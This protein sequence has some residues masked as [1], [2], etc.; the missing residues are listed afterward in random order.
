MV[1]PPIRS[2]TVL[3]PRLL[4][5]L[6]AGV[7]GRVILLSAPAGFGKTT[8]MAHWLLGDSGRPAA[9][10]ELDEGDNDPVRFWSYFT[11][12]LQKLW[13]TAGRDIVPMLT[14]SRPIPPQAILTILIN[15]LS[16]APSDSPCL[17]ALDDLHLVTAAPI[18]EGL[19]FFIEHMPEELKIVIG[20]RTDPEDLPLA[21]LRARRQLAE[22]RLSD[23]RF[24][25]EEAAEFLTRSMKLPLSAADI[26]ALE[27]RTEGWIAGLQ[28]A[29]LSMQ[30]NPDLSGFI[31]AFTGSNRFVLDYLL[32]EVLQRE[33]EEIR[34][35]LLN[36]CILERLCAPLCDSL[37]GRQD[38]RTMLERLESA[39]LFLLPLDQDRRWYRYH[40]LF[41]DLLVRQL[42]EKSPAAP[43]DL[44]R[45]AADWFE[46]NNDPAGAIHH[47]LAA[48]E[49]ERAA[50]I[51]DRNF[52]DMLARSELGTLIKW[53]RALPDETIRNHPWLCVLDAWL[54]ILTGEAGK[55]ESRLQEAE[56]ALQAGKTPAAEADRIRGYA[57][58][59]RAQ[60][61]FLQGAI[62]EAI[63]H[64]GDALGRL[65]P[66]D[67]V[68]S[69]TTAMIQGAA[70]G[71]AGDF[72]SAIGSFE[73]AKSLSLAGGN[74]FNAML[75]SV[76]LAQISAAR[77]RLR[78]AYQIYEDGLCLTD[79]SVMLAPGYAYAHLA[80]I[81]REWD[82]LDEALEYA[83]KGVEM[84]ELLGQAD[85]LMTAYIVLARI[86]RGRGEFNAAGAILEKAR[87]V[88]SE[89]SAWSLD[90][91][92]LQQ[93]RI[94]LA[95]GNPEAAARWA[96]ESGYSKDE[97]PVFYREAGLL[98]LARVL[99]A[100]GEFDQADSLLERIQQ[101]AAGSGSRTSEIESSLLRAVNFAVQRPDDP[102][103]KEQLERAI[104]LSEPEGY[105]RIYLDEGE[106]AAA[107]IRRLAPKSGL[108]ERIA[109]PAPTGQSQLVEPLSERELEVLRLLAA[110]RSNPEIAESL[111][112]SLNTV[113]AH[114]KSIFTKLGVHNRSQALLR[115]QE[116]NLL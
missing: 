25:P 22:I 103:A 59:I 14:A 8:L 20:T 29:A 73:R 110:G 42:R 54:L 7:E 50:Q 101:K 66:E 13:P 65:T 38:G 56:A 78:D 84:C 102:R 114:V 61:G 72:S 105:T 111:Y 95:S 11:A 41:S 116:L 6:E 107:L 113:K 51:V 82:R 39:N 87:R 112:V 80:D 18:H 43:P 37:T 99:T 89:I 46:Q 96:R 48:K 108:A 88:A 17:L 55:I 58:A 4:E 47:A 70:F 74:Q 71:Y 68:I 36:T 62:P 63:G 40:P 75:G 90:S 28:M 94:W 24:T 26:A 12:A 109:R 21:R 85:L 91:V 49:F 9:W 92:M 52:F 35:F 83:V 104:S 2:G 64:A 81:L 34:S 86:Q 93:A 76:G 1:I 32:E 44:H 19:G 27:E 30:G 67:F 100:E 33:R 69:A 31:Q 16:A 57:A 5:K 45:R 60:V 115:A 106:P 10:L 98:T 3:R 79:S 97:T 23:L 53:L 15:E 77:G